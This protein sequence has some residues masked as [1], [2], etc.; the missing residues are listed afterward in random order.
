MSHRGRIKAPLAVG[1]LGHGVTI[2]SCKATADVTIR[3]LS[4]LKSNAKRHR[5]IQYVGVRDTLTG[6]VVPERIGDGTRMAWKNYSAA[7]AA[8]IAFL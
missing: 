2:T 6:Y 7:V 4:A 1:E 5:H 8:V 3:Y